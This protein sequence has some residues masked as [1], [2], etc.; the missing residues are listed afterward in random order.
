MI[1]KEHKYL[2][3]NEFG[4]KL[5]KL[6]F[7]VRCNKCYARGAMFVVT[8]LDKR[9]PIGIREASLRWNSRCGDAI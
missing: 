5:K 8:T 1:S 6:G 2:G 4:D 7:Y 3:Q 9:D